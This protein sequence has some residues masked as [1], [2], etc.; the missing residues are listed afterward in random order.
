MEKNVLVIIDVQNDFVSGSLGSAA[1]KDLPFK[2]DEFMNK[3]LE[4]RFS[5][6]ICTVDTHFDDSYLDTLEGQMLPVKHCIEGTDGIMYADPL[7]DKMIQLYRTT[8]NKKYK[9]NF[10]FAALKKN[11]FGS[12]SLPFEISKNVAQADELKI[13]VCGLCTDICVVT[14]TLNLRTHYPNS[15]IYVLEDL[16][17][18]TST[19]K[20]NAALDVMRSCQCEIIKSQDFGS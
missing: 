20:H 11:T 16:C 15:H 3:Y 10:H 1:A 13:Y 6:L 18:G 5:Q 12:I 19:E 14:N 2:I 8:R 9:G 4:S 7:R 17:V